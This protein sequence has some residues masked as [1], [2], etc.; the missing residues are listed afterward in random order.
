MMICMKFF[1]VFILSL[2][3][4]NSFITQ[5]PFIDILGLSIQ[6]TLNKENYVGLWKERPIKY[7]TYLYNPL[8]YWDISMFIILLNKN[9][10]TE[11]DILI[12]CY[13]VMFPIDKKN[14][15]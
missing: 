8:V 15:K 4:R 6:D 2:S 14:Y 3:C 1:L 13:P 5:K 10:E 11:L 12:T 7:T 9:N